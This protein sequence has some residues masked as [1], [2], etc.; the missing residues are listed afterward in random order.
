VGRSTLYVISLM[1]TAGF[2][3][4]NAV[5]ATIAFHTQLSGLLSAHARMHSLRRRKPKTRKRLSPDL[6]EALKAM[7]LMFSVEPRAWMEFSIETSLQ[8][9]R[10][11]RDGL[12]RRKRDGASA[13][14]RDT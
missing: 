10:A 7:Q 3:G 9:L 4:A 14:A 6:S 1:Q 8:G 13:S 5:R 2:D 12:R 11:Q